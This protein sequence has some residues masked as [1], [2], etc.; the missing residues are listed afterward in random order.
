[1][2]T[3]QSQAIEQRQIGSLTDT[4]NGTPTWGK[5]LL[6]ILA[7][8]GVGAIAWHFMGHDHKHAGRRARRR[9][10]RRAGESKRRPRRRKK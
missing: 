4:W 10:R 3:P 9:S 8:A 5:W 7:V 2:N 1:M 6:A